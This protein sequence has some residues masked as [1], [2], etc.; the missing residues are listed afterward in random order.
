MHSPFRS[1]RSLERALFAPPALSGQQQKQLQKEQ[2]ARAEQAAQDR[3]NAAKSKIVQQKSNSAKKRKLASTLNPD[4]DAPGAEEQR[5]GEDDDV[6]QQRAIE[7]RKAF[8]QPFRRGE[9]VLLVG[10]GEISLPTR[11]ESIPDL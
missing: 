4:K 10:E 3:A 9:R 5:E 1:V 8:A 2:L 7:R 11:F 6:R